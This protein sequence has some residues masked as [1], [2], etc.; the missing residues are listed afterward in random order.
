MVIKIVSI[1][2]IYNDKNDCF[3]IFYKY[4]QNDNFIYIKI[5]VTMIL[6][7]LYTAKILLY[8]KIMVAMILLYIYVNN[9]IN[10]NFIIYI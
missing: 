2:Y 10:D 6:L 4:W 7:Y 5:M 1:Y 9:S 3:I 8:I